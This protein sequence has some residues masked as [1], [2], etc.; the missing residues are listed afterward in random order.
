MDTQISQKNICI[1]CQKE[2]LILPLEQ[3]FYKK[4]NLPLP[5]E[6]P[7]CRRKKRLSLRNENTLYK[8]NCDNCSKTTLSTYRPDSPYKV[9]CKDCYWQSL[10]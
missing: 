9:F 2:F 6:C 3:I 1:S 10:I 8:R 7:E 5:E 4:K